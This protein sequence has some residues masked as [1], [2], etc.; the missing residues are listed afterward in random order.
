MTRHRRSSSHN[1]VT[2]CC[3]RSTTN[4]VRL[5]KMQPLLDGQR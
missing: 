5:G 3:P 1:D 4:G 2:R